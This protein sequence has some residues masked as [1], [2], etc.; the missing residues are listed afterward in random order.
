MRDL[1]ANIP[2]LQNCG[3]DTEAPASAATGVVGKAFVNKKEE[4]FTE[5][6]LITF[7]NGMKSDPNK[8]VK[9]LLNAMYRPSDSI[10]A[11]VPEDLRK[12]I[13][14]SFTQWSD[15][16]SLYYHVNYKTGILLFLMVLL[17]FLLGIGITM[18]TN[19]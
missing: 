2:S 9:D 1:I 6:D 18:S 8:Q 11:G 17:F 16:E 5:P 10:K 3:D 19:R 15:G 4:K 13:Y 7:L 14:K 12:E